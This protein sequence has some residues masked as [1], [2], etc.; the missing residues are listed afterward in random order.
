MACFKVVISSS[1]ITAYCVYSK[2]FS[3]KSQRITFWT[4]RISVYIP[5]SSVKMDP[6][7][8]IAISNIMGIPLKVR[9]QDLCDDSL[10]YDYML[11]FPELGSG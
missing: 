2:Y 9:V 4:V 11:L 3:E 1:E 6:I 8:G 7:N 5:V 10:V